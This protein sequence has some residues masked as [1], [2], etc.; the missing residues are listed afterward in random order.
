MISDEDT[1]KL[2]NLDVIRLSSITLKQ[3]A[4]AE[5]ERRLSCTGGKTN[6]SPNYAL[7]QDLSKSRE[8]VHEVEQWMPNLPLHKQHVGGAASNSGLRLSNLQGSIQQAVPG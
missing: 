4:T 3:T 5:A 8:R 1:T 2:H 7:A 6:N